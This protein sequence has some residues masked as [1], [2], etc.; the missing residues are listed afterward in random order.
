MLPAHM[1]GQAGRCRITAS[2]RSSPCMVIWGSL[3]SMLREGT[4][5][6]Q[7]LH[8]DLGVWA[9]VHDVCKDLE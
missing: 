3:Q 2:A 6:L 8:G 5:E 9:M 1:C 4:R 7:A